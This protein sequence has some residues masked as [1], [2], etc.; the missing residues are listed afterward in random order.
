M[1]LPALAIVFGLL[2]HVAG[3]AAD[4]VRV[5]HVARDAARAAVLDLPIGGTSS[6][7]RIDVIGP[8]RDGVV[9]VTAQLRSRWLSRFG[10]DVWVTGRATMVD[11]P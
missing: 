11:E 4:T 1:T 7:Q 10:Q 9:T 5:Q 8:S 3:F 6:D 2:L